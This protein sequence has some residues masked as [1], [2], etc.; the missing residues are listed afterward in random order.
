MDNLK[1]QFLIYIKLPEMRLFWYFLPLVLLLFVI[2]IFYLPPILIGITTSLFFVLAAAVFLNNLRLA[3]SNFEAR[4]ERNELNSVVSSLR[5]GIIAYDSNF[6]I[7]LLNKA[8]EQIFELKSGDVAGKI[9]T[10]EQIKDQRYKLICQALFPSLAAVMIKRSDP[11][12]Y[13]QVVDVSIDA[14]K[15]ELRI[16]T[17]RIIDSKGS[18]LGF[19]KIITDRTREVALLRSKNEFISVA[20]H[21][22]RTPLTAVNWIFE[23]LHHTQLNDEQ[24]QLADSGTDVATYVLK[25]V[26][27]LLD[28]SKMEEGKFGYNFEKVDI[29]AFVEDIIGKLKEFA[30]SAGIK[31]NFQK[32]AEAVESSID[33]QKLGM[34]LLNLIDNA[35]RYNVKNGQ[36]IVLLEQLPDKQY[37]QISV[38]DTGIGIPKESLDK[39]FSKFYRAENAV[40]TVANGSGLGLYIAKNIV[41][42]HSGKIWVESEINRGTTFYFTL[43]IDPTLLPQKEIIYGE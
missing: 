21:Q 20:A 14:P 29:I 38:K 6:K 36:V 26:N 13:P 25:I 3:K 30:E 8:A 18:L 41:E 7:L 19:V 27:D 4:I 9:F 11:G 17:N 12:S 32:P 39:L 2:E 23:N 43:P 34:V 1:Q 24:K 33:Q 28:V 40:R 22:L 15:M 42:R 16:T 37:I 5:D 31:V 35:I 10:P